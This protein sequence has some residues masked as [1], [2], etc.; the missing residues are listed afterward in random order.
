[1]LLFAAFAWEQTSFP[2]LCDTRMPGIHATALFLNF[3]DEAR[4]SV[5]SQAVAHSRLIFSG[6]C[7]MSRTSS[8]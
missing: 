4:R 2:F 3:I 6:R 7:L 1:M 5:F 8:E